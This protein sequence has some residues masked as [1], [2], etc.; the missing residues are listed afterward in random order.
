LG[1][2]ARL[3]DGKAC[4]LESTSGDVYDYAGEKIIGAY[5]A[6]DGEFGLY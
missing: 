2:E 5:D 3:I 1:W 4:W 6:E